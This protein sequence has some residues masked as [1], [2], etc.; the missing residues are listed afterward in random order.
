MV[1]LFAGPKA[2]ASTKTLFHQTSSAVLPNYLRRQ[3][4]LLQERR[5]VTGKLSHYPLPVSGVSLAWLAAGPLIV[6]RQLD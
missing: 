6:R 5:I 4:C 2:H 3:V 1:R